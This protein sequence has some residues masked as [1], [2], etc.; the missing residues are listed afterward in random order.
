M[1]KRVVLKKGD[2]VS[3]TRDNHKRYIQYVDNDYYQ[4]NG[5]VIC[6]FKKI[7]SSIDNPSVEEIIDDTYDLVL[8]TFLRAGHSALVKHQTMTSSSEGDPNRI[9]S[10]GPNLSDRR[11]WHWKQGT[12]LWKTYSNKYSSIWRQSVNVNMRTITK[13][14]NWLNRLQNNGKLIYSVEISSCVT[15]TSIAL[16][17]SGVFNIGI[18][19]SLLNA[20]MLLWS[21]GIRPWSY[22]HLLY[23]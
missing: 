22:L 20:E 12:N 5:D 9:I 11:S 10:V 14:A 18:F 2:I 8:H 23:Y 13:Y 3:I 16:N 17:L 19:P 6:V 4:L 7:Y 15:H 21:N 1:A